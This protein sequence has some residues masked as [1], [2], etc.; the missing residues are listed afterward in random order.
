MPKVIKI[1]P[2][3]DCQPGKIRR[4]QCR[5]LKCFGPLHGV[6]KNVGEA[7]EQEIVGGCPAVDAD[8]F[9]T[10]NLRVGQ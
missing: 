4:T 7:L 8:L 2:D 3:P 6:A 10:R 9:R 5:R 1:P